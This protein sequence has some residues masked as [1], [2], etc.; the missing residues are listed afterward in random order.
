MSSSLFYSLGID[1]PFSGTLHLE[2]STGTASGVVKGELSESPGEIA[3]TSDETGVDPELDVVPR[4]GVSTPKFGARG[5]SVSVV[6]NADGV[7]SV[8]ANR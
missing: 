5:R 1:R 4:S 3:F 8:H 2:G 7:L 6:R